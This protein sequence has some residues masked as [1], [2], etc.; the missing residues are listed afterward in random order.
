MCVRLCIFESRHFTFIIFSRIASLDNNLIPLIT[1]KI[2][3]IINVRLTIKSFQF[4]SFPVLILPHSL[5]LHS[6]ILKTSNIICD[7]LQDQQIKA[8]FALTLRT[9]KWHTSGY[10][11]FQI[12]PHKTCNFS[13]CHNV[14]HII[15]T[16]WSMFQLFTRR[17]MCWSINSEVSI[18]HRLIWIYTGCFIA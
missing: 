8:V 2:T 16:V 12:N 10:Q 4:I 13:F 7:N 14:F 15:L 1:V 11:V 17:Y 3:S 5:Y 9:M 18:M 6:S